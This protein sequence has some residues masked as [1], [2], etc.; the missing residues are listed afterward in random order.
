MQQFHFLAAEARHMGAPAQHKLHMG[1]CCS[2]EMVR[3]SHEQL[4]A[5]STVPRRHLLAAEA[6]HM[7]APAQHEFHL[8]SCCSPEMGQAAAR[9]VAAERADKEHGGGGQKVRVATVKHE[10]VIT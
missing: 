10:H 3:Q 8:D 4:H 7:G 2:P 9:T 6:R 5:S 1:L